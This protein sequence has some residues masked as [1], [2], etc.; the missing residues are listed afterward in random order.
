[1][2]LV[3]SCKAV[4]MEVE[5]QKR[6]EAEREEIEGQGA[7]GRE[8]LIDGVAVGGDGRVACTDNGVGALGAAS[9]EEA[10]QQNSTHLF[11]LELYVGTE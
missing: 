6:K 1:M 2:K 4:G 9:L 3:L 5:Q 7:R 8:R 11:A 10:L